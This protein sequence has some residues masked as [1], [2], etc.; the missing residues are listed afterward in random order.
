MIESRVSPISQ[1][2]TVRVLV[3]EDERVVA[4]DIKACL[5][6]LGYMVPAIASSGEDAIAQARA[7]QP[8]LVLMDIRL[9]GEMDG[10]QAAQQIWNELQIPIVYSSGYSDRATV[11]RATATAPFGYILK[12]IR[13]RDLYV[14]VTTALQRH[15]LETKLKQREQ[16]LTI[17]LRAIGD[18]VIVTDAQS[19]VKFLNVAAEALTDWKQEEAFD[20][21][22]SE[23]FNLIH[24]Q[25]QEPL[26]DLVA[27]VLQTGKKADLPDHALLVAKS[28]QT[29]PISDCAAP[30]FDIVGTLAGVV[31]VFRDMTKHRLAQE[32]ALTLQ[33]AQMLERQMEELQRLNQLKD[34]FLATISHEL[35]T[36][37]ANIKMTIQ[38][39]EITLDQQT[40]ATSEMSSNSSQMAR[41]MKILH[42]Q[43]DQ[44]LTLINDLLD[45]QWLDANA[46]PLKLTSID[47]STWIPHI[48]EVFK[49][50]AQQQQQQL[51][52]I[53]PSD[54]PI[55]ITDLKFLTRIVTELLMNACKYT[56]PGQ[57]ITVTVQ[58]QTE[59][60]LQLIVS[61]SGVEIP[62]D[63]LSRVFDKF[64]R[65]ST[66]DRWNRGGTGLGL[67]LIK[68][69]ITHL[70]GSVWAES[71]S[72]QTRFIVELP[73]RSSS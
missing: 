40:I 42:E 1:A 69:M 19:R 67:A 72:G 3:V 8:D 33:H 57:A 15:Q 71:G 62:A 28:G 26:A 58:T 55:L 29:I 47:L 46:Y 9:E 35:R 73:L 54:L 65:I 60:S 41:Y 17:I 13:E 14:A 51:Q 6:N 43:C 68:K 61:N 2:Q 44:E 36:P 50:R 20:K 49:E 52:M 24:E 10:T 48:L 22:A 66:S 21:P 7:I 63:E 32:Q 53:V 38:L 45:L 27:E 23:V 39:L 30:F 11:E 5:E 18:G 70:N 64:Y 56:P 12:P 4:R 25:T 59:Y 37:L 31:L 16:W 34:D